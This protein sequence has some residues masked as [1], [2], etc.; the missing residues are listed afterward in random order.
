M[1]PMEISPGLTVSVH[2]RQCTFLFSYHQQPR[3]LGEKQL[4]CA[5]SPRGAMERVVG[6]QPALRRFA[7]TKEC[8]LMRK[9]EH[10]K[11]NVQ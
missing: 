9:N 6:A 1:V 3:E 5:A 4:L 11:A 7:N 2:R 10:S 8:V